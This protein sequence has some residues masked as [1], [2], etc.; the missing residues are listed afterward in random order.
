MSESRAG[1]GE[2][3]FC[4]KET[5]ATTPN[6][7]IAMGIR[8]TAKFDSEPFKTVQLYR[9]SQGPNLVNRKFNAAETYQPTMFML[10][11]FIEWAMDG[12]DVQILSTKQDGGSRNVFK[13]IGDNRLGIDFEYGITQDKRYLKPILEGAAEVGTHKAFIDSADSESAVDLGFTNEG[14]DEDAYKFPWFLAIEVPNATELVDKFS[15]VSRQFIIKTPQNKK[16]QYNRSKSDYINFMLE[17]AIE[18]KVSIAEVVAIL[19]K[20]WSPS[21]LLKEKN[22]AAG[23]TYDAFDLAAGYLTMPHPVEEYG[24]E[25]RI[26]TVKWEGDVPIN[27]ISFEFGTGKGGTAEDTTGTTGGT[28]KVT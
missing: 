28:L 16:L 5:L 4:D 24:D 27:N 11:K 17:V 2:I 7:A 23:T 26:I 1:L 3:A 21:I 12:A 14:K 18:A 10:K 8:S 19:N 25:N 15:F 9:S 13:F 6:D 20:G 22:D